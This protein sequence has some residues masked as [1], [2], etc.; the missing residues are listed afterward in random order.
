VIADFVRRR[1][2]AGLLAALVLLL[3]GYP[4]ADMTD[5][6]RFVVLA[7]TVAFLLACLQQLPARSRLGLPA[8]LM[9][10]VWLGLSLWSDRPKVIATA[11]LALLTLGV[12]ILVARRLTRAERVDAELL[13]GAVGAYLLLGFF[14]AETYEIIG[15]LVPAAF[16]GPGGVAPNRSALIYFSFTT[17]TTTGYGDITAVDPLVRMWTVFEAIVGTMYNAT[18]IA[19]LVSLYGNPVGP[20]ER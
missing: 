6:A 4:I 11:V 5:Q 18:V 9:I 3:L 16:A 10:L 20:R 7:A 1:R 13:C 12:L 8:R 2:N 15:A 17:L 19:R 14:W